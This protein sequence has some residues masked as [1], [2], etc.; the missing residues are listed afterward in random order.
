MKSKLTA[1]LLCWFFGVWGAHK[2]YIGDKKKGWLYFLLFFVCMVSWI[3]TLID[4]VRL[5][6]M[7]EDEF[8]DTIVRNPEE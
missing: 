1:T 5:L 8:Q 7:T 3:P 2:F 6:R 4:F